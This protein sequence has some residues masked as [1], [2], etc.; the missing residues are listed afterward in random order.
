M[1][2]HIDP[3]GGFLGIYHLECRERANRSK[4]G[5]VRPSGTIVTNPLFYPLLGHFDDY[6][7]QNLICTFII[8]L[9]AYK[10]RRACNTGG[11]KLSLINK[12][13]YQMGRAADFKKVK[14]ERRNLVHIASVSTR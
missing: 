6:H 11:L 2:N 3:R 7:H 10:E 5:K 4:A 1:L 12:L 8:R 13:S 9:E 14:P